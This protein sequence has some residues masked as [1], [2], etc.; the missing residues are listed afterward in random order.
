MEM[1]HCFSESVRV[2]GFTS[3]TVHV[4]GSL[5]SEVLSMNILH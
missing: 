1:D 3:T 5:F 2:N 4:Y